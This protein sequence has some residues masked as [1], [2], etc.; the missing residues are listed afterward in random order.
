MSRNDLRLTAGQAV[1][2]DGQKHIV[3]T[4]TDGGRVFTGKETGRDLH[5]SNSAQIHM[6]R[7]GRITTEAMWVALTDGLQEA[8]ETDWDAFAPDERGIMQWRSKFVRRVLELP[9]RDR[10]K[11]ACV[12]AAI[13]AVYEEHPKGGKRPTVRTVRR[14]HAIFEAAGRDI[15]ALADLSYRKGRG[16]QLPTWMREEV[17]RA[18]DQVYATMPAGTLADTRRRAVS[19]VRA[20]A[21]R[22]G[23]TIPDM[24]A[25][26][27]LGIN[28]VSRVLADRE[29]YDVLLRREGKAEADRLLTAVGIGPQGEYP[30]SAVEIDHTHLEIIIIDE[31][32]K[33]V[34]GRPWLTVLL[35]RFSR[36]ILGYSLSF[37]PPS[38]TTVMEAI[39]NGVAYKQPLLDEISG[40]ENAWD[41]H[42][43]P[44]VLVCDN[45]KEFHSASMQEMEAALAMRILYLPRKKG[46]LKGKI[47]RWFGTLEEQIFHKISGTTLSNVVRRKDYD[48]EG[49]AILSMRQANW[50]IAKWVVDVYHQENHSKTNQAPAERWEEGVRLRGEKLPPPPGLLIPLTGM[51]VPATLSREGVKFKRLCWNSN[52]FSALRNRIGLGETVQ[53]R[54]DPLDL[55]HAYA[56]DAKRRKWVQGDL[57]TSGAEAGLT[58]HQYE[59]VSRRARETRAPGEDRLAALSRARAEIFEYVETILMENRKSKAGKR[60]ARFAA[61]GRKPSEHIAPNTIDPAASAAPLGS[62]AFDRHDA[63]PGRVA[64]GRAK[65]RPARVIVPPAPPTP[66]PD[67][68]GTAEPEIIQSFVVRRRKL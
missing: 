54:I 25:K 43:V 47:E 16:A 63:A 32:T 1:R 61:D 5:L 6:A 42:G 45:G 39:R 62:H 59:V 60:F 64:G 31:A 44:D 28:V 20:R 21:L 35:D 68:G 17:D 22:E 24:G 46:W 33:V 40:I 51:V 29:A 55:A 67:P 10:R 30:L 27:V 50:L 19:L 49:C 14:W 37:H 41:C 38:W 58:L 9:S 34:C 23:L 26:D 36:C 57:V 4:V 15:R 53:V 56:F 7:E 3:G 2:I 11:E 65:A 13:V 18:I 52:A 12:E 66:S 8:L 48:S